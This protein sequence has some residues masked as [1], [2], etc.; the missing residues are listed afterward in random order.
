MQP[1]YP[2]FMRMGASR[3]F[4]TLQDE[5]MAVPAIQGVVTAVEEDKHLKRSETNRRTQHAAQWTS[6]TMPLNA[7]IRRTQGSLAY[8]GE[9]SA[10]RIEA[11][12]AYLAV[13]MK[14]KAMLAKIANPPE[15]DEQAQQTP[16]QAVKA[17]L[18][19][20]KA[21][22]NDGLHWSDWVPERFKDRITLMF[23]AIPYKPRAKVKKPFERTIPLGLYVKMKIKL[24][25]R[26]LNEAHMAQ[27]VYNVTKQEKDHALMIKAGKALKVLDELPEGSPLPRDWRKLVDKE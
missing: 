2:R 21:I 6:L 16:A 27:R 25:E 7:E 1:R 24:K 14:V 26:C 20:D 5:G 19:T 13:L 8:K 17:R 23:E 18:G 22:P 12:E 4:K 15:G 11:L 10:E 3:I 9:T